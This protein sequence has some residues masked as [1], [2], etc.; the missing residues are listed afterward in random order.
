MVQI[1][2]K[3]DTNIGQ[4]VYEDVR[5]SHCC[6]R[7][8]FAIK[9]LLCHSEY[10]Y[11]T[12]DSYSSSTKHRINSCFSIGTK[13]YANAPLLR[14]TNVA[15]LTLLLNYLLSYFT[16]LY[17]TYSLTH[18]L[19]PCS[20][21]LLE[22]LTGFQLDKKFPIFYGTRRFITAVTRPATCPYPEP[23]RSSPLP[24]YPS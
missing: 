21:V 6:R 23:A 8:K 20:R 17:F 22:K 19:T 18:S 1:C 12:A 11:Y 5:M 7:H 9:A 2:L 3:C 10:L 13:G 4:S 15:L 24:E 14:C 16:L